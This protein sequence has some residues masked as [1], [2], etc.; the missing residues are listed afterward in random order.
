MAGE[1]PFTEAEEAAF[2]EI[3]V[4]WGDLGITIR[5]N[6]SMPQIEKRLFRVLDRLKTTLNGDMHAHAKSD[7]NYG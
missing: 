7:K 4:S 3:T 2:N 1:N 6:Q 5:G